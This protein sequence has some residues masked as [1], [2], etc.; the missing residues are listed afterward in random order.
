MEGRA[1]AEAAV[2]RP[3]C[4]RPSGARARGRCRGRARCRR[5]RGSCSDRGDRT[6]RRSRRCS[7][8]R[9]AEPWSATEKRTCAPT[10]LRRAPRRGRRPG[11]YLTALSTRL[12]STRPTLS[13]SPATSGT[14]VGSRRAAVRAVEVRACACTTSST[15][16]SGSQFWIETCSESVSR[17]L[18]QRMSLTVR[19]SRSASP[20]TT[21][22]RL[23]RCSSSSDDVASA[24]RHRRAVDRR[25]RRAQLVRDGRDELGAHRSSARSS[26]RSRNA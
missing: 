4:G 17:R 7:A 6:S 5:R 19:A 22:S 9:D 18:A 3:R 25:E 14:S 16:A 10:R 23:A 26:V 15:S 11:E 12:I 8:R 13:G 20:E 2:T 1:A 24:Q 21:S